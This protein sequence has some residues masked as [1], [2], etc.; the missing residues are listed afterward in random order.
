MEWKGKG[1]KDQSE[2][3]RGTMIRIYCIKIFVFS[4]KKRKSGLEKAVCRLFI[5]RDG[6]RKAIFQASKEQY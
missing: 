1:R 5:V 3:K 4:I 6:L 2:N